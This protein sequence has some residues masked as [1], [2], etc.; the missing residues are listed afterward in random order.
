MRLLQF[1]QGRLTIDELSMPELL[2]T[3]E[4]LAA[5]DGSAI[6]IVVSGTAARATVGHARQDAEM[7]ELFDT[8]E[9]ALGLRLR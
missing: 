7:D 3:L 5:F 9:R 4:M 2:E 6:V 1:T 8:A